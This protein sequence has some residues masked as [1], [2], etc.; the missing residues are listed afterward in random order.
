[1]AYIIYLIL[2]CFSEGRAR[3]RLWMGQVV[4]LALGTKFRGYQKVRIKMLKSLFKMFEEVKIMQKFTMKAEIP[5]FKTKHNY[6][7]WFSLPPRPKTVGVALLIPCKHFL[8]IVSPL[9]VLNVCSG[10]EEQWETL[11]NNDTFTCIKL[12]SSVIF[13]AWLGSIHCNPVC[14]K[15]WWSFCWDACLLPSFSLSYKI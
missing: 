6:Y 11:W 14:F 2:F 1:M 8:P 5:K 12:F 3:I 13:V 15:I 9:K 7:Y 4:V 10:G